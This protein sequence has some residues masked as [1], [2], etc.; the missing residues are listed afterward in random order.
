[1]K[2]IEEEVFSGDGDDDGD[3]SGFDQQTKYENSREARKW[4]K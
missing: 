2:I 1:M 3:E 4:R